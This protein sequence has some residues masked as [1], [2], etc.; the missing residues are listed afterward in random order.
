MLNIANGS[1]AMIELA[2]K[3]GAPGEERIERRFLVIVMAQPI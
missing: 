2:S 1:R 3:A